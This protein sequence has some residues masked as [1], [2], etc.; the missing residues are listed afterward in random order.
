MHK[1]RLSLYI[2]VILM[3]IAFVLLAVLLPPVLS[4]LAGRSMPATTF[5]LFLFGSFSYASLYVPVY[6]IIS[7]ALVIR[8]SFKVRYSVLLLLSILPFLTL[9]LFFK[10]IFTAESSL[11][12]AGIIS[13]FGEKESALLLFLLFLVEI[14]SIY[15]ISL[16]L[17]GL[18]ISAVP[19]EEKP[20]LKLPQP[21]K[22]GND[23]EEE[24][25][26]ESSFS[27]F[28]ELPDVPEF[29]SESVFDEEDT[30]EESDEIE[31]FYGDEES[32]SF[33]ISKKPEIQTDTE[34]NKEGLYKDPE[35]ISDVLPRNPPFRLELQKMPVPDKEEIKYEIPADKILNDYSN[36]HYWIIDDE[37][38]KAADVLKET[39][40]EFKIKAE[41]TGIK[42][43]PVITMFEI[44]PAPG[45]KL[46]KIV[47]LAD[48]IA[49]RLAASRIRIVAP[50]PGKHA[51]GI[52][53]PNRNRAIVSFKEMLA[54]D[55]FR[56]AGVE[57]PIVLGKDITGE[58]QIVDLVQ[59]PHL[60]IAGATGSGK[61]VCVNSIICSIL[62]KRKP[63]E[64]RIILID[65]K[66]VE[67]KLYND[68]PHLL[69]PVITEPKR[70]FQALQYCIYEMER[71]YSLL[72]SLGVRD[73]RA[74]NKKIK[75]GKYAARK[76][77]YIVVIVD[78][79]AD[80]IATA[81]KELE[82]TLARL[83]A[84][85]RAVGIH[86]VLATQR[87]SIDVITGLIKANIPSRIAF[88]VAN[89]ID[90][91]IILDTVGADKLLGKG[92]MLFA[93]AWDPALVR[94]QGAFV[95]DEEVERLTDYVKTL[96]EPDY[97]DE[98]IFFD[99]DEDE[100]V[101]DDYSVNDPLMDKS[102]EIVTVA[103]KASASYL[104]RRLKIG[105]NRAA[106]IVEEME[107][108]GIVGPQN[109]SK[110]REI[111]HIPEKYRENK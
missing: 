85:A 93:S 95:S 52:E 55:I 42:K 74:Y 5:G 92:D 30:F 88:M 94:I 37:T 45:V 84:M 103:G 13:L 105:Y 33:E 44:L 19:E 39:L 111:L 96:G 100:D 9:G 2:A 32:E 48:N 20:V 70:A 4:G 81:G 12:A 102:I 29:K 24:T 67:L 69:T 43:G 41:V 71:R 109:G 47:N 59:T 38:R 31:N 10:V 50:I 89:K 80:L 23:A 36:S 86:L 22:S 25:D 61:S 72:D 34:N 1:S 108:R 98:E 21:E 18:N 77:P 17:S 75:K 91:R 40:E 28:V 110:P 97:I 54:D 16:K 58:S 73:I 87:P 7:A 3:V 46:S 62:Y 57:I 6:F 107:K 65:P 63:E 101:V 8:K 82:S 53:V 90:S 51:V 79:F 26:A 106:R 27:F 64:V 104:Q 99:S 83:A 76:L 14:L 15:V 56:K 60:L 35:S 49:L 66:I 11:A 68:I 78:E